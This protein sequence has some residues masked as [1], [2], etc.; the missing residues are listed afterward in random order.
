MTELLTYIQNNYSNEVVVDVDIDLHLKEYS[1]YDESMRSLVEYF[2]KDEEMS[3][4]EGMVSLKNN[5]PKI[6]PEKNL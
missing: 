4:T 6:N 1:E 5:F 2:Y 3:I